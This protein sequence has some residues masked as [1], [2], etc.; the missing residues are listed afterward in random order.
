MGKMSWM[1]EIVCDISK[2]KFRWPEQGGVAH[3]VDAKA[4]S[5]QAEAEL[6]SRLSL[7][8]PNIAGAIHD[9]ARGL[10]KREGYGAEKYGAISAA[11]KSSNPE[12]KLWTVVYTHE[13]DDG[14]RDFLPH[15]DI[16]NLWVWKPEEIPALPENLEKCRAI[17]PGK[18]V[19]IGCYLRDY[20]KAAPVPME[21][22]QMQFEMTVGF[23]RDGKA[24]GFSILG[25]VLIDGQ[26]EQAEWA[27][28]FIATNS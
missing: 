19:I 27:R 1:D 4:E 9:D 16:V 13:L 2:W 7:Q 11:L 3:W 24:A 18:P 6:V 14:W 22:L 10:L 25:A 28:D 21:F 23:I 20:G 15:V 5:V 26:L 17:F 8:F 12:M